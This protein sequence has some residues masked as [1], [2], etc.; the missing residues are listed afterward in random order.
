M[1]EKWVDI[2]VKGGSMAAFQAGTGT[3]GIVMLQEVF[4]VNPAMQDK[5]LAEALADRGKFPMYGMPTRVRLL[6]T[7]PIPSRDSF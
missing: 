4:G 7:R 1:T 5:G 3:P 6:Q 2:P